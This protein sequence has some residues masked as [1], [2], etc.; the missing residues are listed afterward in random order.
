MGLVRVRINSD[1][2][3]IAEQELGPLDGLVRHFGFG[4]FRDEY[5]T[6]SFAQ[7]E[8]V[9]VPRGVVVVSGGSPSIFYRWDIY[10]IVDERTLASPSRTTFNPRK[11]L[12]G[13]N[14]YGK[15]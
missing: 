14:W 12:Q 9:R 6:R 1:I 4:E 11:V 2:K 7:N 15:R 5:T 8:E 3:E 10:S 13:I